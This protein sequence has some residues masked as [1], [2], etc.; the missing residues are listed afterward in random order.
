M[1]NSGRIA[2]RLTSSVAQAIMLIVLTALL[3]YLYF[4]AASGFQSWIGSF[5]TAFFFGSLFMIG[6]IAGCLVLRIPKKPKLWIA[7]L[8]MSVVNVVAS[9]A[10]AQSILGGPSVGERDRYASTLL[11]SSIGTAL[12]YSVALA[13][14]LVV[15]E[16]VRRRLSGKTESHTKNK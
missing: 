5:Y 13:L 16:V 3:V 11:S 1:V 2:Y 10:F 4:V 8:T 15:M 12:M 7:I 14:V 9:I 6:A